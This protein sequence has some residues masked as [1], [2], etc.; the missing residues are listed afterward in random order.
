MLWHVPSTALALD[1]LSQICPNLV[2]QI[3]LGLHMKVHPSL[4]DPS[5]SYQPLPLE[6]P[7]LRV[8]ARTEHRIFVKGTDKPGIDW[9]KGWKP[10]VDEQFGGGWL[11]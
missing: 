3:L 4:T 1:W 5:S 9:A 2:L 6:C 8:Q 10:Y 7:D 11:P